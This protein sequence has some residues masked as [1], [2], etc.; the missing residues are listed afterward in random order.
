M[1]DKSTRYLNGVTNG[2]PPTMPCTR[3]GI[4]LRSIP[5]DDGHVLF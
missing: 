5:A 2:R 1:P 4:P 3:T